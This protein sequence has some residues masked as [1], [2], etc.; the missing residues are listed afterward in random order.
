MRNIENNRE[1]HNEWELCEK[2]ILEQMMATACFLN[3]CE[4]YN[5]NGKKSEQVWQISG[6]QIQD[7]YWIGE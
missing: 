3:L 6:N 5:K 2:K 7:I 1:E 4:N